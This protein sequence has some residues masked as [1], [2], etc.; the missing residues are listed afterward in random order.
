[1][2]RSAARAKRWN[3]AAFAYEA[4][5]EQYPNAAALHGELA[6]VYMMLGDR[7]SA[8]L[9]LAAV[10]SLDGRLTQ[11]ETDR[12]LDDL[13]RKYSDFQVYGKVRFGGL[14][15]SNVNQGPA[16]ELLNLGLWRLKVPDAK[17]KESFGAYMG[18][19]FN[20]SNRFYR[21]SP[22]QLVGDIRAFWKGL[23]KSS[24]SDT[25][26]RE[27]QWGRVALGLRHMTDNALS[28]L[29]FKGEVF[30]YEFERRVAAGGIEGTWLWA[31]R[32]DFHL[33]LNGGLDRRDYNLDP[34][35]N[36]WY[37]WL[38]G[39]S[40]FY[41]GPDRHEFLL[42]ARYLGGSPEKT[43]YGYQGWEGSAGFTFKLPHGIEVSPSFSYTE[44]YYR[45]P[46]TAMETEKRKDEQIRAG[47]G[48]TYR[49]N[50]SWSVE[51]GYNYTDNRSNSELY[52][53]G[54]NAV[55]VGLVWSF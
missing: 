16:S 54:R 55:N 15:D 3:Q 2:A 23:A 30:D 29:K 8:E 36:G 24:L 11:T 40:R 51:T 26:S 47:L 33:I 42:G 45:G 20:F 27:S 9:S 31:V 14:Y 7:A 35:R 28:E 49:I 22:W 48:L 4:L 41:M 1:M 25:N 6:N 53:Y 17:A 18:A 13:D 44:E 50:E 34:L 46:A 38:G 12:A 21:D 32:P 52:T 10:R 43:A 39:H 5:L 37:G 19:D